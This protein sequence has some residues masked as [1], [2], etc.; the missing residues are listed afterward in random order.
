MKNI[1]VCFVLFFALTVKLNATHYLGSEFSYRFVG[2]DSLLVTL[3]ILK[4]CN[5]AKQ[6]TPQIK[7][8]RLD[9]FIS[10]TYIMNWQSCKD[11]SGIS[12]HGC[13]RCDPNNCN[14]DGFP[15]GVNSIC[16]F[17]FGH[18]LIIYTQ[19]I[20]F[21]DLYCCNYRIEYSDTGRSRSYT[22]IQIN[23]SIYNY[24]EINRCYK[25]NSI[26]FP[27]FHPTNT[28]PGYFVCQNNC[29][30]INFSTTDS[31]DFDSISYQLDT[32]LISFGTAIKYNTSYGI[33]RPLH[34]SG[35]P[36]TIYDTNSCK[37]FLFDSIAG[38]II[39][40]PDQQQF[41]QLAVSIKEWRKISAGNY[42][43]VGMI[44]KEFPLIITAG[45]TNHIPTISGP[46]SFFV[47][48]GD[49][50]KI[51]NMQTSDADTKDTVTV[52]WDS[53]ISQGTF[54]HYFS[55]GSKK[56]SWDFIWKTQISDARINPYSF[57]VS[58]TDNYEPMPAT[59]YKSFSITVVTNAGLIPK[60]END[61][62]NVFPN[63][64]ID[65][66]YISNLSRQSTIDVYDVSGRVVS[67]EQLN[68]GNIKIDMSR[69]TEGIYFIKIADDSNFKWYK[70][71]KM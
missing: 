41:S 34:F 9:S 25:N 29:T 14:A 3:K 46:Y 10:E 22:T 7:V 65:Y 57:I 36:K 63:P 64:F 32:P 35:F 48:A 52:N 2:K 45:C 13:S 17:P 4:D 11:V 53:A 49:T 15:N 6:L 18:E 40:K 66:I 44:R 56:E 8:V 54:S 43:E 39:F 24:C 16:S 27:V 23:D 30:F 19:I 1:L 50:L 61:F 37:G 33:R 28:F 38:Q 21:K 67:K 26:E 71:I 69:Y 42:I 12:K 51:Q 5:G 20:T 60:Q 62:P 55:F 70:I 58:A 47:V 59:T 68:V 31:L